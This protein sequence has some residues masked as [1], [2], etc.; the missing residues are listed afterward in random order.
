MESTISKCGKDRQ[1]VEDRGTCFRWFTVKQIKNQIDL[2]YY[3]AE[4][5]NVQW[6][7]KYRSRIQEKD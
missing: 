5:L 7:A 2:K 1:G 6:T 4:V 3:A